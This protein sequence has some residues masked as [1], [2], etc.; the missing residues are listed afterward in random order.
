MQKSITRYA[1]IVG[2]V[3]FSCLHWANNQFNLQVPDWVVY[4]VSAIGFLML[5]WAGVLWFPVIYRH[6]I[7][8]PFKEAVIRSYEKT[9]LADYFSSDGSLNII[10]RSQAQ[11][12][13]KDIPLYAAPA[14]TAKLELIPQQDKNMCRLSDDLSSLCWAAAKTNSTGV[15]WE[16]LHVKRYDLSK[17]IKQFNNKKWLRQQNVVPSNY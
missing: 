1:T 4:T 17:Q 16:N 7:F 9:K 2:G 15:R 12:M 6:V 3:G 5:L 10:L 13:W 8:V 11:L 14:P